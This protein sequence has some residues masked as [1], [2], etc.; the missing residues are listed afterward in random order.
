[1][2]LG[3]QVKGFKV[4]RVEQ[5][6]C[7]NEITEIDVTPKGQYKY[8]DK[9]SG[10]TVTANSLATAKRYFKKVYSHYGLYYVEDYIKRIVKK[11]NK[12]YGE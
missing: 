2:L 7:T 9:L 6:A 10:L 1:M 5:D 12:C 8:I 3:L 11:T 4:Y